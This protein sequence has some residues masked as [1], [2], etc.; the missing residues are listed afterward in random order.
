M[1]PCWGVRSRPALARRLA[2]THA[3]DDFGDAMI[4][5]SLVGSLFFSASLDAGPSHTARGASPSL[6]V[7]A[8]VQVLTS[9]FREVTK[10]RVVRPS[11]NE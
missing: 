8:T 1:A 9:T 5:L 11:P 2:L 7:G 3:V 10:V 4:N 6:V